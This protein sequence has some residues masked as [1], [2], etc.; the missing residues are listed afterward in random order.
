MLVASE[1]APS[2]STIWKFRPFF[3]VIVV[4]VTNVV[5]K[6]EAIE[7]R[8]SIRYC[9]VKY[10]P[11]SKGVYETLASCLEARVVR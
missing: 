10:R 3:E 5:L 7:D 8:G 2:S 9:A 1:V 6:T 11:G 4:L